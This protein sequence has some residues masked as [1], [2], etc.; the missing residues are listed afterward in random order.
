M[1]SPV[2]DS[3]NV[4]YPNGQSALN[5]GQTATITVVAHDPDS[6]SITISV[7]VVDSAGAH[8]NGQVVIPVADPITITASASG[9]TLT[10]ASPN[11]FTLTV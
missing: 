5:P 9:G 6:Q 1:A 11:S 7:D 10:Q 4:T 2:I 3:I 8:G